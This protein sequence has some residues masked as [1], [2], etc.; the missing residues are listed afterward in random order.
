MAELGAIQSA[1]TVAALRA[2]V[3]N[4]CGLAVRC[5]DRL[6]KHFLG[7]GYRLLTAIR[8]QRLLE[9]VM[10]LAAPGSYCFA[11]ARTRHFDEILLSE[12]RCGIKQ[13]VLLG[14]GYDSRAFR[15]EKQLAG[16]RLFEIDHPGTQ[17]RKQRILD[18]V[19]DA[20]PVNLVYIPI[21]F[22]CQSLP[23][24]LAAHGFSPGVKTLFLWEGVSY[25][26][27]RPVV[28]D[29]LSLVGHCAPGSSIIFDYAIR[30]FVEGD[31]STYGGRQVARWL[32]R[33]REPFVF[34]LDAGETGA[35][36]HGCK[37]LVVSDLGPEDLEAAY[38]T[39][40]NGRRLGRIF[41]HVRMAHARVTRDR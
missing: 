37:L 17:T 4:E 32:K 36:L 33:I 39:T 24:A 29:V 26:L 28:R 30:S 16:V 10:H 20:R 34:G 9:R 23:V 19:F 8:P 12:A 40:K 2:M 31:T 1:E 13:V 11:I 6:A 22:N 14:A 18:K 3:A 7:L 38:L 15:F 41:G 35:F 25:Y 5:E 21:D 27:P